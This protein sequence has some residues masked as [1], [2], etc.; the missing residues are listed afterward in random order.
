MLFSAFLY[1]VWPH[2]CCGVL[3]ENG[4]LSQSITKAQRLYFIYTTAGAPD[5]IKNFG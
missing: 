5:F 1:I 2:A 3:C 4:C